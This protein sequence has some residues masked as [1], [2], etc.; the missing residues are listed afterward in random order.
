MSS[1]KPISSRW[2]LRKGCR[3]PQPQLCR[4]NLW[5]TQ[6]MEKL[7]IQRVTRNL[8]WMYPMQLPLLRVLFASRKSL[9]PPISSQ[10]PVE[11]RKVI[12]QINLGFQVLN[13]TRKLPILLDNWLPNFNSYSVID[14]PLRAVK[15][16]CINESG[17]NLAWHLR[18]F[19]QR[20]PAKKKCYVCN[21]VIWKV[22]CQKLMVTS[23]ENHVI[24]YF[25]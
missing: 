19:T 3:M 2:P 22:L 25:A 12:F 6:E 15:H 24:D 18:F 20:S 23:C 5:F 17:I 7:R 11:K 16:V 10:R 4:F 14:T 21:F 9:R 8:S 13:K 1:T